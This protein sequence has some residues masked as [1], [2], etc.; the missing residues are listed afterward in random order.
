MSLGVNRRKLESR[1]SNDFR[2]PASAGV[3]EFGTSVRASYSTLFVGLRVPSWMK[4]LNWDGN[5]K[6]RRLF[7]SS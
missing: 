7:H 6:N 3:T 5:A 2:T 1:Y 4:L